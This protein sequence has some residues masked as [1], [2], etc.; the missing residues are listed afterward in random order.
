MNEDNFINFIREIINIGIG[1]AANS[2]SKLV[3]T[4]VIIKVPDIRIVETRS[5]DEYVWN[6]FSSLG[7]YMSQ[8]FSGQLKGKTLLFYTEECSVSLLNAIYGGTMKTSNLTEVGIAT[9][10]EIGNIIMVSCMTQIIDF[11]G[12]K[13]SFDLP[14]VTVEVSE[15]YFKNLLKELGKFDKAVVVKNEMSIKD[16]DIQG[17]LFVMLS[18]EDFNLLLDIFREKI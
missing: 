3:N 4:R 18:F 16:T 2:L 13:L 10:H 12:G 1:E 5:I 11:I 9:L 7:V 14:N 8:D 6:E 15:T 17:Y